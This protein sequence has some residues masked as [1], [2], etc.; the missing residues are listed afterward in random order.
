M[1]PFGIS[2]LSCPSLGSISPPPTIP[3]SPRSSHMGFLRHG[4]RTVFPLPRYPH[5]SLSNLTQVFLCFCVR[6]SERSSSN[7][8]PG[9]Y[10]YSALV[11]FSALFTLTFFF[12]PIVSSL[13]TYLNF[14]K[15][16]ILSTFFFCIP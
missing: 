16:K 5:R 13:R 7:H 11:L 15:T 14:L 2:L 1:R 10:L 6:S 12:L 4:L 3:P 9:L 8:C